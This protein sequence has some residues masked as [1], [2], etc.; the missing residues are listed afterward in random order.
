MKP[1]TTVAN[2]EQTIEDCEKHLL[3]QCF[4]DEILLENTLKDEIWDECTVDFIRK[5]MMSFIRNYHPLEGI[6][7]DKHHIMTDMA[8]R[9][10]G[11]IVEWLYRIVRSEMLSKSS[12][13]KEKRQRFE[14]AVERIKKSNTENHRTAIAAKY[15]F[16]EERLRYRD[17]CQFGAWAVRDDFKRHIDLLEKR[18][19]PNFK[20]NVQDAVEEAYVL[21]DPEVIDLLDPEVID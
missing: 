13:L 20:F 5:R 7:G 15:A 21:L 1:K 9:E 16:D 2:V 8:R 11:E 3:D 12:E 17:H 6:V 10:G 4:Q 18:C 19:H 14:D